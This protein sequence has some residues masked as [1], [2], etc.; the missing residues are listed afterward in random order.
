MLLQKDVI[1]A[2]YLA[3][4]NLIELGHDTPCDTA[5]LCS[6]TREDGGTRLQMQVEAVSG[7]EPWMPTKKR[8]GNRAQLVVFIL[9]AFNLFLN[10]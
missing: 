7:S 8:R 3:A 6:C 2:K 4:D 1:Y 9:L 10:K 5:A